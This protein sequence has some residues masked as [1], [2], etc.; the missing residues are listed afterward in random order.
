MWAENKLPVL[1][2][3]TFYPSWLKKTP[4]QSHRLTVESYCV[5][6]ACFRFDTAWLQNN[7]SAKLSSSYIL[8]QHDL[9]LQLFY[10]RRTEINVWK[11]LF[12]N[13][14]IE[15]L[16]ISLRWP[17][18]EIFSLFKTNLSCSSNS[19]R[20][21]YTGKLQFMT[22]WKW[23]FQFLQWFITRLVVRPFKCSWYFNVIVWWWSCQG[24]MREKLDFVYSYSRKLK[25]HS[26]LT[27]LGPY[28]K[29]YL[30]AN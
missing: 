13:K 9:H 17:W 29:R 19:E 11:A 18:T 15:K 3:T 26:V 20:S 14:K 6:S 24:Q 5:K 4:Y 12:Q 8:P 27:S 28:N 1:L 23:N 7:L 25:S 10:H 30:S 16:K 22:I 2:T 21:F